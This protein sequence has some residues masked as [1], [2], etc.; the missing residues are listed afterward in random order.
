MQKNQKDIDDFNKAID[1][2]KY[3]VRQISYHFIFNSDVRIEFIN[4]VND[5]MNII[6]SEINQHCLSYKGGIAL[7]EQERENLA[8]QKFSLDSNNARL[9]VI[10]EKMKEKNSF[11]TITLKRVGFVSGSVQIYAGGSICVG[12]LGLACAGF[13]IPLIAHGANNM[14]ENGYYLLYQEDVSGYTKNTYRSVASRLGYSNN[15]A[16]IVYNV[17]DLGLSGFGLGRQ[18]L[19]PDA[20][21]LFRYISTD[22]TR[23]WKLMSMPELMLEGA[24]D[25]STT[26]SIYKIMEDK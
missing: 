12:S 22:Y 16:D 20:T 21:K 4:E 5:F 8:K 25:Y 1:D 2:L 14:Y 17:V 13:G 10:A 19:K 6:K 7:L 18:V 26:S 23:G 24:T 11:T 3:L 9:F 15:N